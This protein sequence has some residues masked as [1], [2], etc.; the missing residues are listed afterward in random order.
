MLSN[1][2]SADSGF[3]VLDVKSLMAAF[4]N[5]KRKRKII[6]FNPPYSKNVQANVGKIFLRYIKKHFPKNTHKFYEIFKKTL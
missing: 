3:I 5:K 2:S 6:W 4:W 1:I